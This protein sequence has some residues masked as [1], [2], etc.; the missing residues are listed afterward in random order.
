MFLKRKLVISVDGIIDE[1][2]KVKEILV[3][4]KKRVV[5]IKLKYV[6][7]GYIL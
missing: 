6:L 5:W 3:F 2:M 1:D 7:V 4:R